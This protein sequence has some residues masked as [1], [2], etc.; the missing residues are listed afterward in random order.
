MKKTRIYIIVIAL[1]AVFWTFYQA[2]ASGLGPGTSAPEL[3]GGPW[4]GGEPLK[5]EELRGKVVLL[6]MWTFA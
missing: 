4:L 5:I 2:G 1:L 6:D 3:Q